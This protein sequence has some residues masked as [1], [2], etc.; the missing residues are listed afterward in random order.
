VSK[1]LFPGTCRARY[2]IMW[3]G[4]PGTAVCS[5]AIVTFCLE[6][7]YTQNHQFPPHVLTSILLEHLRLRSDPMLRQALPLLYP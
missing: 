1:D 6:G 2:S 3:L 5:G 4:R 7:F